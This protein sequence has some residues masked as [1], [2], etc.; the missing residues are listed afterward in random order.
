[1]LPGAI[2]TRIP[3]NLQGLFYME[4][5]PAPDDIA[6]FGGSDWAFNDYD[7]VNDASVD[8]EISVYGNRVWSWHDNAA[9]RATYVLFFSKKNLD[10]SQQRKQKKQIRK[11]ICNKT[12]IQL[13]LQRS[14]NSL[15][16]HDFYKAKRFGCVGKDSLE[17][18]GLHDGSLHRIE[19]R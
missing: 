9:G 13:S 18:C 2:D 15:R 5:N 16:H 10:F 4:G 7:G 19:S 14:C 6:S 3:P 1:M 11:G 8:A 12:Y 17:H